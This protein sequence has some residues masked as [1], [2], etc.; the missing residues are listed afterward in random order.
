MEAQLE[1]THTQCIHGFFFCTLGADLC[2]QSAL[3]HNIS[4]IGST[5][6]SW[7]IKGALLVGYVMLLRSNA[8][9]SIN[10][11]LDEHFSILYVH[12]Y[13]RQNHVCEDRSGLP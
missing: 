2:A 9:A 12:T 4:G 6:G 13:K 10:F 3:F 8:G 11:F 7:F 1:Y 5:V